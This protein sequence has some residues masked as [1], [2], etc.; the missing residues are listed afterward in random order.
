MKDND[1]IKKE[2]QEKGFDGVYYPGECA[3]CFDDF[4]PCGHSAEE[5]LPGYI[6]RCGKVGEGCKYGNAFCLSSI[7]F[8]H[9]CW[10]EDK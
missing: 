8:N 6:I 4:A 5:C 10:M 2:L 9:K 1:Q 7:P 3:C